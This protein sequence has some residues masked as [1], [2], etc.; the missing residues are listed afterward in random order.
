MLNVICVQGRLVALP[1]LKQTPNGVSVC[2]FTVA[3]ERSYASNGE[4]QTDFFDIVAW[5]SKAEFV[6]KYFD[7]GQMILVNGRLETNKWEDKNG[8]KRTSYEIVASDVDFCGSKQDNSRS[9]YGQ[10]AQQGVDYRQGEYQGNAA[11]RSR[12]GGN[13]DDFQGY[14]SGAPEDFAVVDESEDLPF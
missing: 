4:R 11:P 9:G 3:C 12:G 7:K 14:S 5:R 10:E 6:H 8:N 2:R 1:E 13:F